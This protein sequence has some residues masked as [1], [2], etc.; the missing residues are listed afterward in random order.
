[1]EEG[2]KAG[3]KRNQSQPTGLYPNLL[4]LLY[5]TGELRIPNTYPKNTYIHTRTT[6]PYTL[7]YLALRYLYHLFREYKLYCIMY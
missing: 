3:K 4:S 6:Y 1:M 5:T 2:R 7:R